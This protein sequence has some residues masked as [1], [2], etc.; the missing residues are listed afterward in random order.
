MTTMISNLLDFDSY[1]KI[2][3]SNV[4][5]SEK[6]EIVLRTKFNKIDESYNKKCDEWVKFFMCHQKLIGL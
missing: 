2:I 4:E 3:K 1:C 6:F 5:D